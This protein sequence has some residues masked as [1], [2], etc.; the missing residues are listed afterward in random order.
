[1]KY[2]LVPAEHLRE[3]IL[4]SSGVFTMGSDHHYPEEKPAHRVR[5]DA[6]LIDRHTATNRQFAR[7]VEATGH[8]TL[9]ERPADPADYPAADPALLVPSSVVLMPPPGRVDLRNHHNWWQYIAGADWR[10]PRGPGT[11]IQGMDEQPVVHVAYE[12][13]LAYAR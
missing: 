10:H 6:F 12:D 13:A 3:M 4:V 5:V 7:F 9:A 1:M 11:S 8:V 2:S